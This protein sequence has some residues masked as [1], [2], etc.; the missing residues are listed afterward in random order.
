MRNLRETMLDE[1][2]VQPLSGEKMRDISVELEAI[3]SDGRKYKR[4]IILVD[5][6]DA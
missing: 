4:V 6:N 3:V 1:T 5:G 2:V